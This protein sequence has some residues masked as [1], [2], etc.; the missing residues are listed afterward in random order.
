MKLRRLKSLLVP[1]RWRLALCVGLMLLETCFALTLPWLG[2][3]YAASVLQ[4]GSTSN[5]DH[6]VLALL[7]VLAVQAVLRFVNGFLVVQTFEYCVR[8]WSAMLFSHLLCLPTAF[9]DTYRPGDLLSLLSHEVRHLGS[10]V[11]GT[12]LGFVPQ[13]LTALGAMILMI[14]L[15]FWLGVAV[16]IAV[17]VFMLQLR[18][19]GRRLRPLAVASQKARAA[20]TAA[21]E[22][23]LGMIPAIKSFTRE[24]LESER[25][26]KSAD[27]L[28]RT[29]LAYLFWTS[30][31]A[32]FTQLLVAVGAIGILWFAGSRVNSEAMA[33][34][35][36]VSLLLYSAFLARP[37]GA[38]AGMYGETQLAL[39]A[40]DRLG[41]V[42]D[43]KPEPGLSSSRELTAVKGDIEFR[44]VDFSYPDRPPVLRGV[45]VTINAGEIVAI[46]GENGAGKSTLAHL[47]LRLM[48]PSRGTLM[49][50][51]VDIADVNVLSLRRQITLV[52][53]YTLLADASVRSNIGF[54]RPKA[55]QE[56]IETAARLAGAHDFICALPQGYD[57]VIGHRGLKLSG[58]QRQRLALAR[59]LLK[60]APVVIL[61]EATSMVDPEAELTF[62]AH[63]KSV[64]AGRTVLWITHRP[65]GLAIADRILKLEDGQFQELHSHKAA[66]WKSVLAG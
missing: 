18:I 12:I 33:P 38:L 57:T 34:Q 21:Q 6:V 1:Y 61:D 26:A 13:F 9:H 17:P 50:D 39:G 32:P 58:G 29:H 65:A 28:T 27:F 3:I 49:I 60:D 47:L 19:I 11:S 43:W 52:A 22:E 44:D 55:N 37:I 46:V 2:G 15:D 64:L 59:A 23:A 56:D 36:L 42:L 5:L 24:T 30:A 14:K 4:T 53:Q 63:C 41:R 31:L 8:D 20:L 10:F 48:E 54:A 25:H 45:R 35:A 62:V 7:G 40:L 51:G 66:P 16:V